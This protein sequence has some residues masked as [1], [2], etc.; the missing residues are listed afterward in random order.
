MKM[1]LNRINFK[2]NKNYQNKKIIY[3]K[4][5]IVSINN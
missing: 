5:A 2:M 4:I 1:K 3:D